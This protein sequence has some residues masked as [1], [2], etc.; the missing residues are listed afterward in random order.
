MV[1]LEG[2]EGRYG[3]LGICMHICIKVSE[4]FDFDVFM[5]SKRHEETLVTSYVDEGE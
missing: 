1:G 3:I 5:G 4:G 2:V